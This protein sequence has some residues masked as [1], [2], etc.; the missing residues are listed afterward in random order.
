MKMTPEEISELR[1]QVA[2]AA[3]EF[4]AEIIFGTAEQWEAVILLE[5]AAAYLL[6]AVAR[7]HEH[8]EKYDA[9]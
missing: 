4:R 5:K 3:A 1:D 8:H 7:L 6:T 2:Y 9:E